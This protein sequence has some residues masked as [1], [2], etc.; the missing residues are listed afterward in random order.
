MGRRALEGPDGQK[1]TIRALEGPDGQKGTTLKKMTFRHCNVY[2]F[3]SSNSY[4]VISSFN[5][6]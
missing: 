3:K 4:S 5:R 2:L 6:N 1:G